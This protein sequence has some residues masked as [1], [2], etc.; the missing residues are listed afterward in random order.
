MDCLDEIKGFV[1]NLRSHDGES[2]VE[3]RYLN[4]FELFSSSNRLVVS[5]ESS[6]GD[7]SL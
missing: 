4:D 5:L 7:N 1:I 6:F 2:V 3:L